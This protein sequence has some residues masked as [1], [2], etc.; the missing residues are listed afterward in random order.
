MERT[1]IHL[2]LWSLGLRLL[3]PHIL[4]QYPC[5]TLALRLQ[6]GT[7]CDIGQRPYCLQ[8][9]GAE[10]IV[11]QPDTEPEAFSRWEGLQDGSYGQTYQG[12]ASV[13]LCST[14]AN[15]VGLG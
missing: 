8:P 5:D 13:A 15:V 2:G 7:R 9:Y 10:R 11:Q 14:R 3:R 4:C 1:K 12:V 6:H